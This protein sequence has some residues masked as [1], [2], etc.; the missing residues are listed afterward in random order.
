M[1]GLPSGEYLRKTQRQ[2]CLYTAT[3]ASPDPCTCSKPITCP[4]H[5]QMAHCVVAISPKRLLSSSNCAARSR[6]EI[7]LLCSSSIFLLTFSSSSFRTS[8]KFCKR[9]SSF[10]LKKRSFIIKK[11]L[12][13]ENKIAI[14]LQLSNCSSHKNKK[15]YLKTLIK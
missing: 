9:N 7:F 13:L 4:A 14:F 1:R 3:H 5:A 6:L 10:L 8:S 2:V 11:S 12:M 15:G